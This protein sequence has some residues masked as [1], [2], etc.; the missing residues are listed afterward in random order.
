MGKIMEPTRFLGLS[1][2]SKETTMDS[3][4]GLRGAKL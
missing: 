4:C 2:G 3:S 1:K